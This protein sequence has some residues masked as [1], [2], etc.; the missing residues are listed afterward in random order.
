MKPGNSTLRDE[1][2]APTTFPGSLPTP[3]R[4]S[5]TSRLAAAQHPGQPLRLPGRSQCSPGLRFPLLGE[6]PASLQELATHVLPPP[7]PAQAGLGRL[8]FSVASTGSG[9][10]KAE[11]TWPSEACS[12]WSVPGGLTRGRTPLH[13]DPEKYQE[14]KS[15]L[16]LMEEAIQ[17]AAD[18]VPSLLGHACQRPGLLP[19]EGER[20]KKTPKRDP[21]ALP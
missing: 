20:R 5:H 1:P 4:V 21:R 11:G 15:K 8:L 6:P 18:L 17:E 3:G 9:C 12:H 14:L 13:T 10:S 16:L 7:Q 19:P 2:S